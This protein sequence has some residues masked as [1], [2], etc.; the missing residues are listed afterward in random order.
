[1]TIRKVVKNSCV[2]GLNVAHAVELL[3]SDLEY[4]QTSTFAREPGRIWPESLEVSRLALP[5]GKF[6][7]RQTRGDNRGR[8][9]RRK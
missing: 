9:N 1:M 3:A 6:D 2:L 4:S 7:G 8:R 5:D